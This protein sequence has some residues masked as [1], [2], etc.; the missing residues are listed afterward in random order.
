MDNDKQSVQVDK[1]S[2]R[3]QGVVS[4]QQGAGNKQGVKIWYYQV[5]PGVFLS[6]V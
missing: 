5:S 1:A 6:S 3:K 2:N 4:A